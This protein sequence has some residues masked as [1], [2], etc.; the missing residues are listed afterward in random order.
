MAGLKA[1]SH[2]ESKWKYL[3]RKY[4]AMAD[5]RG[6]SGFSWDGATKKIQCAKSVYDEWCKSRKNAGG[7][8][9]M[10]EQPTVMLN[11]FWMQLRKWVTN[12]EEGDQKWPS[13]SKPGK[14]KRSKDGAEKFLIAMFDD[15]SSKFRIIYGEC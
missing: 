11:T 13:V 7:M 10:I 12:T 15:V 5:M 3:T 14:R 1:N 4:N 8:W 9:G 2:I 6:S